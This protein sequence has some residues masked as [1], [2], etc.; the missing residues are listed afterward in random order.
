MK[1]KITPEWVFIFQLIQNFLKAKDDKETPAV[2][3]IEDKLQVVGEF[4]PPIEENDK[5]IIEEVAVIDFIPDVIDPEEIIFSASPL[6]LS[7]PLISPPTD[8]VTTFTA[9][10]P[11]GSP[12]RV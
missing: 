7:K 9:V 5:P 10:R 4:T 8:T 6:D 3:D 2:A 12:F 1:L 11:L